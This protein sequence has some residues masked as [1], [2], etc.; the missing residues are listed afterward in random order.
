MG[1]A[2]A[3][4]LKP[5]W[6]SRF[7]G[8]ASRAEYWSQQITASL[9][10]LGMCLGLLVAVRIVAGP[11]AI[12]LGPAT[13]ENASLGMILLLNLL[14]YFYL[15]LP[16]TA[17]RLQDL[18]ASGHYCQWAFYALV[19]SVPCIALN[20]LGIVTGH[21]TMSSVGFGA[22]L[23][24]LAPSFLCMLQS[25]WELPFK[26]GDPHPNLYGPPPSEVTP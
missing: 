12:A 19:L 2:Q 23:F 24:V 5:D 11:K 26:K 1:P 9:T 15:T 8:R 4:T 17:R 22:G 14:A 10:V 25:S 6:A 21:A 16:V 20:I 13:Q 18:G 7:T 3:M